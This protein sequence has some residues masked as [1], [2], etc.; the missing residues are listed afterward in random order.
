M[1][2]HDIIFVFCRG[3]CNVILGHTVIPLWSVI[4]QSVSEVSL[5]PVHLFSCK[6]VYRQIICVCIEETELPLAPHAQG[7]NR[8]CF[9]AKSLIAEVKRLLP[10][11]HFHPKMLSTRHVSLSWSWSG[12]SFLPMVLNT[13]IFME[14]F[15]KSNMFCTYILFLMFL[16]A[17]EKSQFDSLCF[18]HILPK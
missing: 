13:S 15:R 1:Y 10:Q 9:V 3:D 4:T 17:K 12:L 11:K 6:F 16:L 2:V 18:P 14:L 7:E 8:K 5:T